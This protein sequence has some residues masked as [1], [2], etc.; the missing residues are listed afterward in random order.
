MLLGVMHWRIV[1]SFCQSYGFSN[2]L[3]LFGRLAYSFVH[4]NLKNVNKF[5][6]LTS[7]HN[8]TIYCAVFADVFDCDTAVLSNANR[9]FNT[10]TVACNHVNIAT[11]YYD[12]LKSK[13]I[14][15]FLPY[16]H[17]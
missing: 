4:S 15:F 7:P 5:N 12:H 11:Y 17:D 10:N 2:Y 13:N 9:S 14:S 1:T 16:M 8:F 6:F 3:L